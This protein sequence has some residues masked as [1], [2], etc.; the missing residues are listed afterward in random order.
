MARSLAGVAELVYAPALGA[1]GLTPLGVRVPPP[2]WHG[3]ERVAA[4]RLVLRADECVE[5]GD[6][7][8]TRDRDVVPR[9]AAPLHAEPVARPG[10]QRSDVVRPVRELVSR[11]RVAPPFSDYSILPSPAVGMDE[12]AKKQSEGGVYQ[13]L[14]PR[15]QLDLAGVLATRAVLR[16]ETWPR[17]PGRS[18]VYAAVATR[19][20]VRARSAVPPQFFDCVTAL[21]DDARVGLV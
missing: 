6:G 21:F 3:G 9:P 20:R 10:E 18:D 16:K 12:A 7:L 14:L 1:G 19:M 8:A 15:H 11:I 5:D 4:T 17:L 2:A 13:R